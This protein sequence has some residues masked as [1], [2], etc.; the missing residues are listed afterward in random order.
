MFP[1]GF[2]VVALGMYLVDC[3]VK[4][5]SPV[6]TLEKIVQDPKNLRGIL[7][8]TSGTGYASTYQGVSG[9]DSFYLGPNSPFANPS[10]GASNSQTAN[11]AV[12][13][14]RAQIGKPY[15][16]GATGPGAF[17]CSGLVMEAYKHAGLNLPRTSYQMLTVGHKVKRADLQVGDLV[18]P[19]PG[20]VQIYSGNGN[21]IEAPHTGLN[22]REVKMW[23]FMTARRVVK[24]TA[25][26]KSGLAPGTKWM[27]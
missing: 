1:L 16:W 17:D 22:V 13:W 18:F 14:A 10:K 23:G 21:I 3:A 15:R 8:Q 19:D 20:H 2:F 7:K 26:K 4:N 9:F 11:D 25:P 12:A 27:G 24:D 5:R 6:A